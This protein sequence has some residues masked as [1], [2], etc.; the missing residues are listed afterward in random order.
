M[1]KQ[2]ESHNIE[3]GL[4]LLQTDDVDPPSLPDTDAKGTRVFYLLFTC[5]LNIV[6]TSI[7]LWLVF[8]PWDPSQGVYSPANSV[9]QYETK[10]FLPGV[11]SLR[12]QY[13][14]YPDDNMDNA[15]DDLYKCKLIPQPSKT[16]YLPTRIPGLTIQ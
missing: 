5:T 16:S 3:E 13:Q 10:V 2:H 1:D 4:S 14:G 6:L 11:G 9:I 8:R 7:L 15:W 12:S